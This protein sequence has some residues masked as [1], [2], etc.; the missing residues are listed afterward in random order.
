M[1]WGCVGVVGDSCL[2]NCYCSVSCTILG[3]VGLS[4]RTFSPGSSSPGHTLGSKPILHSEL[5]LAPFGWIPL[6]AAFNY[7][8]FVQERLKALLRL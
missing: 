7:Y 5:E 6:P 3:A 8:S 4:S 1:S 2:Y